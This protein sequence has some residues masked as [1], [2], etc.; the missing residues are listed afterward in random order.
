MTKYDCSHENKFFI[1]DTNSPIAAITL[2]HY[3]QSHYGFAA[4]RALIDSASSYYVLKVLPLQSNAVSALMK[5][6]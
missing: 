6:A 4:E 3:L 2:I 5:P 1:F